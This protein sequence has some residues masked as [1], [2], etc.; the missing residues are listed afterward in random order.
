M[1]VEIRERIYHDR[2]HP[3]LSQSYNNL[4]IIYVRKKQLKKALKWQLKAY[5]GRLESK[6]PDSLDMAQ[7]YHN[8]SVIYC[9][10][11]KLEKANF[12][13]EK[14]IEIRL[15]K[16]NPL[17]SDIAVSYDNVSII[18]KKEEQYADALSYQNKAIEIRTSPGYARQL[19]LAKSYQNLAEILF[20]LNNLEEALVAI[21]SALLIKEN[22]SFR[23]PDFERECKILR[24]K[25]TAKT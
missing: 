9:Q 21:D 1:A 16:L 5:F 8:L 15:D 7:S 2:K 10:A 25:I 20:L 24:E 19:P 4:S 6:N 11:C 12:Y 18:R 13:S 17:S 23:L 3:Y 22:L 14:A